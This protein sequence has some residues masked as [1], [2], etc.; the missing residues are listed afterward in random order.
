MNSLKLYHQR[1]LALFIIC[2]LVTVISGQVFAQQG[3][4]EDS[5]SYDINQALKLESSPEAKALPG[6]SINI[7]NRGLSWSINDMV[8]PGIG[9]DIV[10]NRHYH[11]LRDSSQRHV[12]SHFRDWQLG[13]PKIHIAVRSNDGSIIGSLCPNIKSKYVN[14]TAGQP[15][16]SMTLAGIR[17]QGEDGFTPIGLEDDDIDYPDKTIMHFENN[18]IL[19]CE[20]FKTFSKSIDEFGENYNQQR[21]D[22][23]TLI[24]PDGT[25]YR[26]A[27]RQTT[28]RVYIDGIR[29]GSSN[30]PL[31]IQEIM[32]FFV[33]DIVDIFGNYVAFDYERRV[34]VIPPAAGEGE[35][36]IVALRLKKI[37]ASDG[38]VVNVKGVLDENGKETSTV[39]K[40]VF[41]ERTIEY[42]YQAASSNPGRRQQLEK[43][44]LPNGQTWEYD[45]VYEDKSAHGH[46]RDTND[47]L[48]DIE[49]IRTPWGAVVNYQYDLFD[50]H[51]TCQ[52]DGS[53]SQS[54]NLP[55]AVRRRIVSFGDASYEF[56][57][58]SEILDGG[59]IVK[60]TITHP[61]VKRESKSYC[62][63]SQ[64]FNPSKHQ[65]A[66]HGAMFELKEFGG[67]NL[68]KLLRTTVNEWDTIF[69]EKS[70]NNQMFNFENSGLR[71]VLVSKTID[72]FYI[73]QFSNFNLFGNPELIERTGTQTQFSK[74]T[75]LDNFATWQL[76]QP[77]SISLSSNGTDYKTIS[78]V[79]YK[80]LSGKNNGFTYSA[81][82]VDYRK[83]FG[84]W[85]KRLSEYHN[86]GSLK[87]VE[88]NKKLVNNGV[89]TSN[90]R[91]IKFDNY[92]RGRPQVV[93]YPSRN[94]TSEIEARFIVDDNGW[95]TSSTD[96]NGNTF[97]Y[98]YD[99]SGRVTSIVTPKSDYDWLDYHIEYEN[100]SFGGISRVVKRCVLNVQKSGCQSPPKLTETVVLDGLYR[101][102]QIVKDDGNQ[103]RVQVRR[104][105]AEN[106][107][108]F[109]S[110]WADSINNAT[111]G[112]YWS[113]DGLERLTSE[114]Q[115]GKN[116]TSIVYLTGNRTE[117][118]DAEGN[119][120]VTTFSSYG[121]PEYQNALEIESPENITT[122]IV[123]N[124]FGNIEQIRQF[125]SS[126]G[127]T[128]DQ[129]EYRAYDQYQRLCQV[130]RKDVGATLYKRNNAGEIVWVANTD[131]VSSNSICNSTAN[132]DKKSYFEYD[133][134][135]DQLS[136]TFGDGTPSERF[137]YDN[138]GRITSTTS[139][140]FEQHY[141]YNSLDLIK[142]E[143]LKIDGKVFV[144][145]YGY[146]SLGY[147]SSIK[148]PDGTDSVFFRPNGFGE[149]TQAIRSGSTGNQDIF[150]K[151]GNSSA[152]YHPNGIIKSFV[153]G[154]GVTHKTLLNA[155]G[156]PECIIDYMGSQPNCGAGLAVLNL[157]Y[158][159]DNNFNVTSIINP[160]NAGSSSI[161]DLKYDGVN[162]LI[163]TTGG[164]FV[165]S[166]T[167]TYDGLGNIRSYNISGGQQNQALSYTYDGNNRLT[168][169]TGNG[170]NGYNFSRHDSYDA[171]GNVT[172]NGKV[173]FAYNIDNQL[174]SANGNHYVYD[175]F[176]RRIKVTKGAAVEYSMYNLEGRLLHRETESGSINYIFFGDKLV[177]KEG[178]GLANTSPV[179]SRKP[180]G[181]SI[182]NETNDLGYTGHK[183]DIDIGLTYMQ[184]RYYDP[185]IGR[186]YS[187]DPVEAATFISRGNVQGFNR[188][189]YANNNPYKYVDPDGK[190]PKG[191]GTGER[192]A[193][194]GAALAQAFGWVSQEEAQMML[195]EVP[196]ANQKSKA[197]RRAS[198][199][200][201]RKK[202]E[203]R[204]ATS[205]SGTNVQGTTH[206]QANLRGQTK[207]GMDGKT[208]I[209]I[210][211]GSNDRSNNDTN[212]L[213][214]VDVGNL[215]AG[216]QPGNN[217]QPRIK[218][219]H[220]VKEDIK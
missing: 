116:S 24:S 155:N 47:I 204:V 178:T 136:V 217:G 93:V 189:A 91:Y 45:F 10:I 6:E 131:G 125:S 14:N 72:N 102:R 157:K 86:D 124:V 214:A 88:F 82:V 145:E 62:F 8:I 184:A 209:G 193:E 29:G 215:K 84:I 16:N 65:L 36:S 1:L 56:K 167:L 112:Q 192:G 32:T 25:R 28:P 94:S 69:T 144:V 95:V 87:K 147:L 33:S 111:T 128:V 18:W 177:A 11:P 52:S 27:Y 60:T 90:N 15:S 137:Q 141:E 64:N 40:I 43:V 168:S 55:T 42:T 49:E 176:D 180:F 3:F 121:A 22:G 199:A 201:Q 186:F 83:R 185:V 163:S 89:E 188:Y 75:A 20:N 156:V 120:T 53:Y 13:L 133:N 92:K 196:T 129:T 218:N 139:N 63:S 134:F 98:G 213:P 9:P 165:G 179:I 203:P 34:T 175:G 149:P 70:N 106:N 5:L 31:R 57:Y 37:H 2:I 130:N 172:H 159:Y 164:S 81:D 54:T 77:L 206:G 210:Q 100:N 48:S 126:G 41:G 107:M 38:R 74:T 67:N 140:A 26:F 85:V 96:L 143:T 150:V 202:I 61:D 162:R 73:N 99:D 195:G 122:N 160:E 211:D 174:V 171:R 127:Y 148:Y 197:K 39:S 123:M 181:E 80:T 110:Y 161:T 182:G 50:T 58:N 101:E 19:T 132:S 23:F 114:S 207:V 44:T 216:E 59:K 158:T 198:R 113:Y 205:Q 187:N 142:K 46:W 220:K 103:N 166:S 51:V 105:N 153:Y 115:T 97:L 146:D 154:N 109:A 12:V 7:F 108:L 135:G 190:A 200:A 212:H 117:F 169:L 66:L 138:L 21:N 183:H 17:I 191:R 35:K 30:R 208:E 119:K 79:T 151:G 68:D 4:A 152:T 173:S 104:Y 194:M 170:S 219:E 71:K 78:E 76:Q 118:L